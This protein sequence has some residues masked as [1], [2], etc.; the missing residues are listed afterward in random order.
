[1]V[2]R[3]ADVKDHVLSVVIRRDCH[4][5]VAFLSSAFLQVDFDGQP[6]FQRDRKV[7]LSTCHRLPAVAEM[8]RTDTESES[9]VG[10]RLIADCDVD[11]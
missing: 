3:V 4:M 10:I 6:L 5:E 7:S 1:M 11:S 9:W 2:R 8:S